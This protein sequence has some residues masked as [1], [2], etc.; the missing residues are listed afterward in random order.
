MKM[1]H[2]QKQPAPKPFELLRCGLD[3]DFGLDFYSMLMQCRNGRV[4]G[5]AS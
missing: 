3:F 2:S 4:F 5:N 1:R